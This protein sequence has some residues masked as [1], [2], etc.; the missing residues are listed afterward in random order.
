[1]SKRL[2]VGALVAAVA[3]VG[4]GGDD[5]PGKKEVVS[6]Y[7][8]PE[9]SVLLRALPV[10]DIEVTEEAVRAT[11][12]RVCAREISGVQAHADGTEILLGSRDRPGMAELLA[13]V[14]PRRLAFYDW[15]PNVYG[16]PDKPIGSLYEAVT[17]A[18]ELTPRD[19]PEDVPSDLENDS[20]GDKYYL[21]ANRQRLIRP[22]AAVVGER[23]AQSLRRDYFTSCGEIAAD[24]R[25]A[26]P[27]LD[28]STTGKPG[29]ET[30]CPAALGAGKVEKGTTVV[31][32][33][34]GIVVLAA[35]GG[36]GY[37]VV[38]D[39]AE[40]TGAEIRKPEQQLDPVTNEPV[41][42]FDLGADGREAFARVT[43]RVAE[44]GT[45]ED[46]FQRFAIALDGEVLSLASINHVANPEGI[47]GSNGAQINGVG[48]LDQTQE[49][50]RDLDAGAL[51]LD[52]Q[53]L[54]GP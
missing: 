24:V 36:R 22:G 26:Q 46:S 44:R 3:A 49:L 13:A 6:C 1:V 40:I 10:A 5:E 27:G 30:Q 19:E 34:R 33:P 31:K 41:V 9:Q 7:A 2:L 39:D 51:P 48:T 45:R 54:R 20:A 52:V 15:E 35:E 50:A 17:R 4:C 21:F 11:A 18:S 29:P 32:V 42:T 25:A 23:A 12:E 53:V 16:S 28:P 8:E 37:W 38:E 14:A 43:K 47:D